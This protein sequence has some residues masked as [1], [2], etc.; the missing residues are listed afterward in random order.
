M[1]DVVEYYTEHMLSEIR[2][3]KVLKSKPKQNNILRK[4]RTDLSQADQESLSIHQ[5]EATASNVVLH[6]SEY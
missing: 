3:V 2:V 4:N 5:L 6:M 1:E